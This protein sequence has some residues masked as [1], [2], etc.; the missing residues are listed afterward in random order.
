MNTEDKQK[1]EDL[2]DNI[3]VTVTVKDLKVILAIITTGSSR[4]LFKPD[5]FTLIGELNTNVKKALSEV[6]DKK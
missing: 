6:L 4:G 2:D 5:E 3:N 1:L